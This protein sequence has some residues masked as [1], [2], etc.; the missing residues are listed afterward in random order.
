[1][2]ILDEGVRGDITV[3]MYEKVCVLRKFLLT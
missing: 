3:I 2:V 1:M